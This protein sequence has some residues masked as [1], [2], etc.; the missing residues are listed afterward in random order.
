MNDLLSDEL[1]ARIIGVVDLLGGRAVHAIAGDRDRYRSV[2]FCHGDPVALSGHYRDLGL[3][4]LYLADLDSIQGRDIQT[5]HINAICD[6][7]CGRDILVDIGWTGE[8]T[9]GAR[10]VIGSL[11]RKHRS[12]R[13]IAATES[14]RSTGA[15]VDLAEVVS[16]KRVMLGLDY[17][18]GQL[19]SAGVKEDEW[20]DC[21]TEVGCHGAVILDLARVGRSQGPATMRACERVKR[22]AP[23]LSIYAGGGI[24]AA[25][26]MRLLIRAGCDRCLVA[27]ALHGS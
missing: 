4:A 22:R 16:R 14:C 26:D 27:T 9:S 13:W 24:R 8:E 17:R 12:S 6:A 21:A 23:S 25:D 20:V 15:I 11:A 1:V 3:S 5:E 7:A 2:V 10:D 19:L 18:M